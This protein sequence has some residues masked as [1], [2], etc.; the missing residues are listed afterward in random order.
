MSFWGIQTH[1]KGHGGKKDTAK[2]LFIC[3]IRTNVEVKK[4]VK[5]EHILCDERLHELTSAWR[6]SD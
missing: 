6:I 4:F 3:N 1:L 5:F 2:R